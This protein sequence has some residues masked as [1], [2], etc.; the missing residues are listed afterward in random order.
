[1]EELMYAI[2]KISGFQYQAE[3]GETLRVPLQTAR[4]G[5]KLEISEVM[6]IKAEDAALI[7]TPY[8]AG[9]TVQAEILGSAKA[10][11][12]MAFKYKRRTKYRRTH[13]HRQD[14]TEIK[15]NKIVSPKV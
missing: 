14:Y 12:V 3:E 13:G 6:L 4:Q 9:A 11:K 7:G 1:V 10:D 5:E 2:F 8:V 15:V